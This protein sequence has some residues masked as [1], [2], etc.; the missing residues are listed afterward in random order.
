MTPIVLQPTLLLCKVSREL[1]DSPRE[2]KETE[3]IRRSESGE[4]L[5]TASDER[6]LVSPAVQPLDLSELEALR[7][8]KT[9][10]KAKT[11]DLEQKTNDMAATFVDLRKGKSRRAQN[12]N[13]GSKSKGL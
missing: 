13:P 7:H 5:V 3:L 6:C 11:T 4:R 10:L 8:E 12:V 2:T 1:E 9:L